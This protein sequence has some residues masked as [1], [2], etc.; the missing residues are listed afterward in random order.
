MCIQ[1]LVNNNNTSSK[2]IQSFYMILLVIYGSTTAAHF[3]SLH[4]HSSR[5]GIKSLH[6]FNP[7][8]NFITFNKNIFKDLVLTLQIII[9]YIKFSVSWKECHKFHATALYI[10]WYVSIFMQYIQ[11]INSCYYTKHIWHA[12]STNK[13]SLNKVSYKSSNFR[14]FKFLFVILNLFHESCMRLFQL[15]WLMACSWPCVWFFIQHW[16]HALI[17]DML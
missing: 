5:N 1:N 12:V 13:V 15:W 16:F 6:I 4:N 8:R 17:S 2:T 3:P 7:R 11:L 10:D 9:Q 14:Q